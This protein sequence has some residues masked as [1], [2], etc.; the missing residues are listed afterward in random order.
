MMKQARQAIEQN[1]FKAFKTE[2]LG[3]YLSG[4]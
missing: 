4:E 1:D 3:E 2:F